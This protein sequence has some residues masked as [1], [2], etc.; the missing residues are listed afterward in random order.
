MKIFF[1]KERGGVLIP[2]SEKDEEIMQRFKN[3]GILKADIKKPRNPQFHKK[4]MALIQLMFD[5]QD[6]LDVFKH[7]LIKVKLEVGHCLETVIAG[8]L[9]L[10]PLS[11]SF[12]DMDDLEFGE[13]YSATLDLAFKKYCIGSTKDQIENE[14]QKFVG[15]M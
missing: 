8:R 7:F 9:V 10:T 15:F 4:G 13:F 14:A 1:R 11:I 2:D 3:G 12:E 6:E 5:N